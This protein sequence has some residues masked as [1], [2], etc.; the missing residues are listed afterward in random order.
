METIFRAYDVRGVY[1]ETLTDELAEK[2]GK[3]YATFTG[4]NTIFVGRDGRLSSDALRDALVRGLTSAGVNVIDIGVVPTPVLYF[5]IFHEKG[6]GGIQITGSHNPPQYNG[7]KLCKSNL[8]FFPEEIQEILKIIKKGKYKT[9]S[10]TE[11]KLDLIPTYI[12]YVV[13]K[14]KLEKKIKIVIDAGNGVCGLTAPE[15]FRKLGCDVITLFCEVDGRFPNRDPNPEKFQYLTPL[16]ERVISEQADLGVAYDGDG[17]R[18]YFVDE[19][20]HVLFGDQSLILLAR[21]LLKRQKGA[22]VLYDVKCSKAVGDEI[23]AAGGIPIIH[24]TGHSFIKRTIAESGVSLAGELSG[25]YYITEGYYNYDDAVFASVKFVDML[26]RSSKTLHELYLTLPKFLSSPALEIK[27]TDQEK[28]QKIERIKKILSREYEII[29]VDG[30]RFETEDGWALLRASN[31][32]PKIIGRIEAKTKE[33]L[34]KL[35]KILRDVLESEKLEL[36]EFNVE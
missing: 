9:G 20:G 27:T 8:P 32:E 10:G 30:V 12:D 3:A 17:D 22:K 18:V 36:P 28:F 2:I 29:D 34:E 35:K 16:K 23:K 26:S 11:K 14:V 24:R 1:G 31:T 33:G 13:S 19:T 7:F 4:Y 15:I 25:H 5:A 21:D 6:E